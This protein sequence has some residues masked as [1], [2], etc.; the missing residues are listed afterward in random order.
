M[1]LVEKG[2]RRPIVGVRIP[3]EFYWVLAEPTPLAGMGYPAPSF[4]WSNLHAAGFGQIVSLHP[5]PYDASP[6]TK[7]FSE[8]LEDLV[9]G[10]PPQDGT[11]EGEKIRR[12]VEATV[13]ALPS[14]RGVV[15]HCFG[16]RGRTGTVVGC[17]LRELGFGADEVIEYLDRLHKA[18]GKP[19]WPES[20]WQ[21]SLVRDW[22]HNA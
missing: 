15:V 2:Q 4:P 1:T 17:C 22:N 13:C 18:R 8:H 19:G 7:I 5:G 9:R 6:L 14:G 21:S 12:A 3:Q 11:Q 16:G 20:P 10:G